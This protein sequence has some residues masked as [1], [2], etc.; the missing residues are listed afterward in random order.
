MVARDQNAIRQ[1]LHNFVLFI[2][3]GGQALVYNKVLLRL[4]YDDVVQYIREDQ[5][6][7]LR[8]NGHVE[9]DLLIHIGLDHMGYG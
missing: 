1:V 5:A 3:H 2:D 7:N 4:V 9:D 6:L 8:L